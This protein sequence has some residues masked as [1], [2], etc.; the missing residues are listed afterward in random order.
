V[1]DGG[2]I[3]YAPAIVDDRL[4][5][6]QFPG[7]LGP[8]AGRNA[9]LTVARGSWITFLDDDDVLAPPAVAVLLD[10]AEHSSL[11]APVA[12]L[13]IRVLVDDGGGER[14][15][16]PPTMSRG[17][18]WYMG[19]KQGR[20]GLVHNTLL[21][22]TAVLRAIDG[23]DPQLRSWQHDDL[24]QR[25]LRRCSLQ[26]VDEVTYVGMVPDPRRGNLSLQHLTAAHDLELALQR[27]HAELGAAGRG[28]LQGAIAMNL[29]VGGRHWRSLR[30]AWAA[31]RSDPRRPWA[32]S[33]LA[34]CLAGPTV[35]QLARAVGVSRRKAAQPSTG[36]DVSAWF[37]TFA[38]PASD[39]QW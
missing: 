17:A 7:T 13:G 19:D 24:F 36:G 31:F 2:R 26:G 3:P 30:W 38:V 20:S 25:L 35:F 10:A 14:V 4:S 21:A 33:R 23:F 27:H 5:V 34:A 6:V 11:P 1:D 9:G 18:N 22:P 37:G 12:G 28:R 32:L 16:R 29:L 15:L 39:H 8:S